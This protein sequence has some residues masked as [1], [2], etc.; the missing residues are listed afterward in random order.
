MS[1]VQ[2][3]DQGEASLRPAASP[4]NRFA[5]PEQQVREEGATQAMQISSALSDLVPELIKFSAHRD[6]RQNEEAVLSARA[7]R[8][9]NA[10]TFRDAVN[11][12]KISADQN[13]WFI[14]T[15]KEMD[16][17]VAADKYHEDLLL[18]LSSGPL[19]N[20]TSHDESTK[21]LD[22]FRSNWTKANLKDQDPDVVT[23]FAARAAGYDMSARE[24]QASRVGNNIVAAAADT[25]DQNIQG[26]LTRSHTH[27]YAPEL[28]SLGIS[29][30]ADK[31]LLAGG[32]KADVN[33]AIIK[34]VA[35]DAEENFDVTH[36][37]AVLNQI[38]TG[39]GGKLGGTTAAKAA[40]QQ[41][42]DN[43]SSKLH[44]LDS[45]AYT[46]GERKKQEVVSNAQM[47]VGQSMLDHQ[48]KGEPST[49][50]EYETQ[51][52]AIYA[53]SGW[54]AAQNMQRAIINSNKENFVEASQTVDDLTVEVLSKHNWSP[55]MY[56]RM[57]RE[58]AAN[59]INRT[60]YQRILGW[61]N[62][63]VKQDKEDA[64]EPSFYK[65]QSYKI[66]FD[67]MDRFLGKDDT[68]HD[69]TKE[70][71]RGQADAQFWT[72]VKKYDRDNPKATDEEK[73]DYATRTADRLKA[74]FSSTELKI[75]KNPQDVIKAAPGLQSGAVKQIG[76][77]AMEKDFANAK[78]FMD[79]M[80][81]SAKAPKD[82]K[83]RIA[84][85]AA[86]NGMTEL[87]YVDA[88]K[89]FYPEFGGTSST[90]AKK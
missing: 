34:A 32:S 31:L 68:I 7:T 1:R 23:G 10:I 15:W 76:A 79:N 42:A 56:D 67:D 13:P 39:P 53:A 9:Q 84:Q 35:V 26:I 86:A 6:Q 64:K 17:S 70:L 59:T 77:P 89:K 88:Q 62:E 41:V 11:S 14:K 51:I 48:L 43:V 83:T 5:A 71:Q 58:L 73:I 8:A 61:M 30:E 33:K 55:A 24:A 21:L 57:N 22:T 54:D 50:Q 44:Q 63:G 45:W 3:P 27:G 40:M 87:E 12:G 47:T 2:I 85:N 37:E 28:T 65:N 80:A 69:A 74:Q 16:G 49:V 4:V 60:T 75:G 18:A 82:K 38:A 46:E 29:R 72:Q 66:Q 19:A 81:A 52:K 36:G 90:P 25:F 20:A 78:D